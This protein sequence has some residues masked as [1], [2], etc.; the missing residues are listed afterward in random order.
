MH[1]GSPPFT[2]ISVEHIKGTISQPFKARMALAG[3]VASRSGVTV[4][5]TLQISS[6]TISFRRTTS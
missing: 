6:G 4:I 2:G 3:K 1:F 5:Q